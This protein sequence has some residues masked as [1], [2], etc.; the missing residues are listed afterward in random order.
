MNLPHAL[1][2]PPH[3]SFIYLFF[4]PLR[5]FVRL[6]QYVHETESNIYCREC[7]QTDLSLY[8]EHLT[9]ERQKLFFLFIASLTGV[10]NR[11]FT[12]RHSHAVC[13][14]DAEEC[15][16]AERNVPWMMCS[17]TAQSLNVYMYICKYIYI[18]LIVISASEQMII[19]IIESINGSPG[20]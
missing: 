1:S 20:R 14:W 19:T 8:G 6:W 3:T 4:F 18:R 16:H 11:H 10:I 5:P 17:C 12:P 13:L 9:E 15:F 2:S 7:N